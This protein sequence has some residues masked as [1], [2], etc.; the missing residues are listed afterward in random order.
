QPNAGPMDPCW[1]IVHFNQMHALAVTGVSAAR[2]TLSNYGGVW[3][4]SPESIVLGDV[5]GDGL[6]DL[7]VR[8]SGNSEWQYVVNRGNGFAGG[9]TLA[10]SNYR[11]YARF[12]DVNGDGRT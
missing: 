10:L 3:T 9:G 6:T 12:A 5:N 4:G 8:G 11:E 1:D 2:V 7:F